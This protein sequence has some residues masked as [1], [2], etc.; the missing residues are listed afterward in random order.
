MGAEGDGGV[1]LAL[2]LVGGHGQV[3]DEQSG[4]VDVGAEG[5]HLRRGLLQAHGGVAA[6]GGVHGIL[7]G[8]RE[9][10]DEVVGRVPWCA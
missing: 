2:E 10:T 5:H 8:R 6:Q 1:E 3:V 7:T 4:L 9:A